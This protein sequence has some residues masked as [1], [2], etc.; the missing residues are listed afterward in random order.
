MKNN[1]TIIIMLC[2]ILI[3]ITMPVTLA[4][5]I[6]LQDKNE[7][8]GKENNFKPG[9]LVGI[10]HIGHIKCGWGW[11]QILTPIFIFRIA[12]F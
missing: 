4:T 9:L 1:T 10:M 6:T 2:L 8:I 7:N 5:E 11:K 3:A 12:A